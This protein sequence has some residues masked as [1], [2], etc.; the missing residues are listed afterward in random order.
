MSVRKRDWVTKGGERKSAWIVDYFDVSGTRRQKTFRLKKE[1]DAFAA[2]ATVEVRAG[3]HVADAA[4]AT[5]AEAAE[6]WIKGGGIEELEL[7]TLDQRRQHVD[8]HI[9]P[10]IGS[11]LLSRFSVPGARAF[12][13]QLRNSG[14]SIAMVRKVTTSLSSIM[15][16]AMERGLIGRNPVR[17]MKAR[18]NSGH[19][20]AQVK[21]QKGKLKVGVDIPTPEEAK[22]FVSALNGPWRAI[23]LT[24]IFTGM[25]ASELRGLKWS[26]VDL[27]KRQI[28]VVE[29]A[30]RY[31]SL[32]KPKSA[33]GERFIPIPPVVAKTLQEWKLTLSEKR[34]TGGVAP[35]ENVG[36]V[37]PNGAGKIQSL[38]NIINRGLCPMMVAAGLRYDSGRVD[39]QGHP[40]FKAKYSGMH[41]LR[42]FYASWCIN[43]KEDGGLGLP[44]KVVQ[45][46]LGHATIALTMDTYGHL[47]PRNN[48]TDE[49][50]QAEAAFFA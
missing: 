17:E 1:A 14:R 33:A 41:A 29:R 18:R 25:R 28:H 43:R 42:H 47:F 31:N 5:I 24:A 48:E 26:A 44:P 4:S 23:L 15:S 3:T 6:L 8:L 11:V 13:D 19:N 16:D 49:M 46:R 34:D 32:G 37:F 10:F 21:R 45:E 9:K 36:L 35:R 50:A 39:K 30:D 7:S 20:A 2:I 12:Q 40:I 38:A 27:E 22:A